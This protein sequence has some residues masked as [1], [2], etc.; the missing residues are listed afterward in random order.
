MSAGS[1]N[2]VW[3]CEAEETLLIGSFGKLVR[4]LALGIRYQEC[5]L[6]SN[7]ETRAS[8]SRFRL[9]GAAGDSILSYASVLSVLPGHPAD[10]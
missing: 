10:S 3:T 9:N 6:T 1:R 2:L 8:G 4:Q 7:D 5:R